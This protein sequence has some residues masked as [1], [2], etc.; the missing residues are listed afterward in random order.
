LKSMLCTKRAKLMKK[1][2]NVASGEY[3]K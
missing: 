3:A 2:E 1:V